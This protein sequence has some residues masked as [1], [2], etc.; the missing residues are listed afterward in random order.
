MNSLRGHFSL[1]T[2]TPETGYKM[3]ARYFMGLSLTQVDQD[4]RSSNLQSRV[5]EF[6]HQGLP[7]SL[8]KIKRS[9]SNAVRKREKE[10]QDRKSTKCMRQMNR[11]GESL[12]E[13]RNATEWKGNW[14]GNGARGLMEKGMMW[15]RFFFWLY[16][17]EESILNLMSV[18]LVWAF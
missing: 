10:N 17:E 5:G 18:P 12:G 3:L 11:R 4:A 1:A 9:K 6:A 14:V 8:T 16:G 7:T 2:G 13:M 15:E